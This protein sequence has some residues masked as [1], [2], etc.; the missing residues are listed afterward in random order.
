MKRRCR[1][2]FV[3]ANRMQ[4]TTVSLYRPKTKEGD[5][6]I[7]FYGLSEYARPANLLAV[8]SQDDALYVVNTSHSEILDS[9]DVPHSALHELAKRRDALAENAVELLGSVGRC[10]QRIREVPPSRRHRCG[11]YLG[12]SSRNQGERVARSRLQGHRNKGFPKYWRGFTREPR[13]SLFAGSKLEAK[14]A[15][16]WE[17]NPRTLWISPCRPTTVLLHSW[18]ETEPT[19]AFFRCIGR[20]RSTEPRENIG[21]YT[22]SG[23]LGYV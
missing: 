22:G 19:R 5:P 12:I 11:F 15:P 10:W 1:A 3:H 20:R 17:A 4:E 8:F 7:W 16:E 9:I 2:F 18:G 13:N 21:R 14:Q 6:R 23:L